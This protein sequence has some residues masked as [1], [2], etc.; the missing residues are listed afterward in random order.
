M[1][2]TLWA[3]ASLTLEPEKSWDMA[4]EEP[5]RHGVTGVDDDGIPRTG[6]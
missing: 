2:P 4:V 6:L 5:R 3:C 1:A